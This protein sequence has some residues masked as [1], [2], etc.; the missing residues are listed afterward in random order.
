MKKISPARIGSLLAFAGAVVLGLG[1]TSAVTY[2]DTVNT[3]SAA[4]PTDICSITPADIAALQTIQNNPNLSPSDELSQELAL[5][6]QL[7]NT[8][9]SCAI[10]EATA[11]KAAINAA[12][13]DQNGQAIQA[14]LSGKADDAITFYNIEAAK[15]N[16]AGIRATEAIAKEIAAWRDAN[17]APLEGDANNFLLWS[18]NQPLFDTAQN[19]LTQTERVVSF[20]E[21]AG[22]GNAGALAT[23]LS[24]SQSAF[25]AAADTNAAADTSLAQLQPPS[26]SLA[27]IQQS[28]QSLADAYQKFTDLNT[29]LQTLLPTSGQ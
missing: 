23:A 26:Q 18:D 3:A 24:A 4:S 13:P 5:R 22:A 15:V 20:V 8:T 21:N 14:A 28:L 6:K 29:L 25:S 9:I 19:R 17:Y 12:N 16:D 2:A 7:L 10:S 27:L 11:L 1:A